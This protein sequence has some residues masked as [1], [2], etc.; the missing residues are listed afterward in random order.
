MRTAP[1][2]VMALLLLPACAEILPPE[3][4]PPPK[5]PEK[6]TPLE[7][8][9]R[10]PLDELYPENLGG[11][12]GYIDPTGKWVITPQFAGASEFSEGLAAVKGSNG[13]FLGYVD[14]TGALAIAKTLF[15]A[16][17]FREERA[18]I[19]VE[20]RG[21]IEYRYIGRDGASVIPGP[22]AEA[23]DF[24]EGLAAVKVSGKWGFVD[25]NGKF[26]I[27]PQYFSAGDFHEGLAAARLES[28][29][30]F[31]DKTCAAHIAPQYIKAGHFSEG[32]AA[33]SDSNGLMGFIDHLGKFII[34]GDYRSVTP[35]SEGL[36]W[37]ER[38]NHTSVF[39][40][41]FG[42]AVIERPATRVSLSDV[43]PALHTF[44][45]GLCLVWDENGK[46]GF[47]DSKGVF[48]IAPQYDYAEPFRG[49]LARV[50]IGDK[51]AYI[52]RGGHQIVP[53]P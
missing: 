50:A 12:F 46:F 42:Q 23:R 27:G 6:P 7:V 33:A 21:K 49:P 36:A 14:K 34:P 45:E 9:K 3:K 5:P 2:I 39:I 18:C 52:N 1:T 29:F 15:V 22:F 43:D 40:D 48:V 37:A 47:I 51:Y 4:K 13:D 16:K 11:K 24:H 53:Q 20:N 28:K 10:Y 26:A 30:G 44:R 31:V 35:F 32:L 17:P 8:V 25:R 41:K 38:R 19:A